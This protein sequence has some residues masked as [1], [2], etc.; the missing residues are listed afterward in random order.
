MKK[1]YKCKYCRSGRY[2]KWPNC[3][4]CTRTNDLIHNNDGCQYY[5]R[6]RTKKQSEK[7]QTAIIWPII[8][9]F[10]YYPMR[11]QTLKNKRSK[12]L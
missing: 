5:W 9:G 12:T 7:V 2:S 6:P 4:R 3:I 10:T 8:P 1:K 11:Q